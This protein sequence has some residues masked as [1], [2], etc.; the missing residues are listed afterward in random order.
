M[1]CGR[2]PKASSRGS[3]SKSDGLDKFALDDKS[4]EQKAGFV[5]VSAGDERSYGIVMFSGQRTEGRNESKQ[6]AVLVC[7][8]VGM[9]D[10][11][12]CSAES[13]TP[14]HEHMSSCST[15]PTATT[16]S[17]CETKS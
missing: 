15:L 11:Q 14:P 10:R 7:T 17:D 9:P 2:F 5:C 13:P 12:P 1:G 8:C 3:A 4:V 16:S 6:V